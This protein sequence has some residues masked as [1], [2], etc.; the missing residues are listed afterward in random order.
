M[1]ALH[2]RTCGIY[3]CPKGHSECQGRGG[4]PASLHGVVRKGLREQKP[5]GSAAAMC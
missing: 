4:G 3:I 5:E 2:I 1:G